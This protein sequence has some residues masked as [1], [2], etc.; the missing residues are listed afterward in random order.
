[1]K[2]SLSTLKKIDLREIWKHEAHDFTDWLFENLDLLGKEI[3]VDIKPVEKEASVGKFSVDILA[4]EESTGHKLV[5]ENQLE[6]TNHDHLGKIVTY[7]SGYDAEII[8]W[9]VKEARDEHKRAIEWLNEHTDDQTYFFLIKLEVWKIDNSKPAPKFEILV[10]PNE[11]AKTFKSSK[12]D[13]KLTEIK[14]KQFEFWDR[15]VNYVKGKYNVTLRK[16]RPK[17]NFQVSIG[18]ARVHINLA[19]MTNKLI[20]EITLISHNFEENRHLFDFLFQRKDDIA[21]LLGEEA[22]WIKNRGWP[23]IRIQK[24]NKVPIQQIKRDEE[25]KYFDWFYMKTELLRKVII[26]YLKLYDK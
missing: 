11:W 14:L 12:N 18:D 10:S 8:V 1:M 15:Y 16:S 25:E 26:K 9:I 22:M 3:M 23:V 19:V 13:I 7:A 20:S 5:I 4:E 24:D 6:E 17:N 2:N 21:S